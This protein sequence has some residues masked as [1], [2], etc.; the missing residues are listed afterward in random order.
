MKQQHEIQL[1]IL[2]K[3][4]FA[5]KLR[6]SD[7]KPDPDMENNQFDF[8]LDKLIADGLIEKKDREYKLTNKGK[9]Y[10][11]RMDTDR[12]NI[13]HQGKIGAMICCTKTKN[14][15]T[16]Y[17]IYT[18]LKQPFFGCQGFPTGKIAY[19]EKVVDGAERELLEETGLKGKAQVV[20][21]KHYLVIDKQSDQLVEDKYMYL[22]LIKNPSG[23]LTPNDEGKFEWVKEADFK[24][25]IT[26]HF[27]SYKN[28]IDQINLFKNFNG[29]V[30]L[31]EIIHKSTKF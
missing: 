30:K 27:E 12:V 17:L 16:E 22:C 9:E 25:Y 14:N 10:A 8:H 23:K 13:P 2:K 31:E 26:N 20:A 4:L 15:L 6:Y 3:A 5:D 24:K 29:E 19:G 7:L 21:I 28:F 1:Q 18:R 11:N